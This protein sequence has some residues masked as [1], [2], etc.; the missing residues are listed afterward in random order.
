MTPTCWWMI[1]QFF[2]TT[3]VESTNMEW[4]YLPMKFY[5]MESAILNCFRPCAWINPE[6][7]PVKGVTSQP[8]WVGPRVLS[9][10]LCDGLHDCWQCFP[11][12]PQILLPLPFPPRMSYG[13]SCKYLFGTKYSFDC[14]SVTVHADCCSQGCMAL[15][16][17]CQNFCLAPPTFYGTFW[18]S[19]IYWWRELNNTDIFFLQ[20][21]IIIFIL[22]LDLSLFFT[23]FWGK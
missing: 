4:L 23:D 5:F 20:L 16:W 2:D 7:M 12:Y 3:I 10:A 6:T 18:S 21:L 15:T 17:P 13:T 22:W 9:G 1:G 8:F 14:V 19:L 11:V